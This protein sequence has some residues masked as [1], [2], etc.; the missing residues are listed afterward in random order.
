MSTERYTHHLKRT[1][2]KSVVKPD[3]LSR[4]TTESHRSADQFEYGA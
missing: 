3:S 4:V 2:A 1:A